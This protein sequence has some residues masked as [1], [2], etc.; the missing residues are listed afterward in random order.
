MKITVKNKSEDCGVSASSLGAIPT[1][2]SQIKKNESEETLLDSFEGLAT[3]LATKSSSFNSRSPNYSWWA[4]IRDIQKGKAS[5][6]TLEDTK[7]I[8]N[9]VRIQ[10][11]TAFNEFLEKLKNY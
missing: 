1:G 3:L 2:G 10:L 8:I 4:D 5:T 7:N 11:N 9:G 6:K